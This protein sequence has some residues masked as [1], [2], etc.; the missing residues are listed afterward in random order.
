MKMQCT[1]SCKKGYN[2]HGLNKYM[3]K[4]VM[5]GKCSVGFHSLNV[6]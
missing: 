3:Y 2:E 4:V 5:S 6:V 1:V